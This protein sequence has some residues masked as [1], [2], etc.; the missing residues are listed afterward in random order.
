MSAPA[1]ASQPFEDADD[2]GLDF[3]P[4]DERNQ[5]TAPANV[6][7]TTAPQASDARGASDE[8]T[9]TQSAAAIST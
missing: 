1:S 5:A 3:Y 6:E 4:G 8:A 9:F 7:A 2:L